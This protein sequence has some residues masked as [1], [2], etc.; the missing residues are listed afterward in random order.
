MLRDTKMHIQSLLHIFEV[1]LYNCGVLMFDDRKID[2]TIGLYVNIN[3]N[4]SGDQPM[5]KNISNSK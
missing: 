1:M 3:Y 2:G 4:I 5:E